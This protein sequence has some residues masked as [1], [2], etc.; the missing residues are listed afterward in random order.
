[1]N[2]LT[3]LDDLEAN[4]WYF[5]GTDTQFR[6]RYEYSADSLDEIYEELIRDNVIHDDRWDCWSDC[7]T[8]L[9]D[10]VL[11]QDGNAYYQLILNTDS[12][13]NV[14]YWKGDKHALSFHLTT[15]AKD[16]DEILK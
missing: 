8:E 3:R 6:T 14:R 5:F 7:D 2:F 4:T 9:I 12:K 16:I 1:M 13:G 10:Y 11:S 15:I